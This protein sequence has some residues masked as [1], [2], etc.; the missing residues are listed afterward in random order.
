MT[1][2]HFQVNYCFNSNCSGI[3]AANLHTDFLTDRRRDRKCFEP[4]Q[5]F[6][7][8]FILFF[9]L[10]VFSDLEMSRS[11]PLSVCVC[12]FTSIHSELGLCGGVKVGHPPTLLH[13]PTASELSG[14]VQGEMRCP[15][16]PFIP[17]APAE[18]L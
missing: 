2:F 4:F 5:P 10:T 16:S 14:S 8:S 9:L 17:P 6:S 12:V 3:I 1:D 15:I 7:P 18:P 11:V 13:I